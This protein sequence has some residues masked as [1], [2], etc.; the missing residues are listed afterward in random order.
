MK[1][2]VILGTAWCLALAGVAALAGPVAAQSKA[3]AKAAADSD[4][5]VTADEIRIAVVADV[6][7]PLKPGLFQGTVDGVN[8]A[9]KSVNANG[10]VAGRKLKVDFIDS[11]LNPATTRNAI[12]TACAED[13]ALVGTAAAFITNVDD[14][15]KC[16]DQSGA[17]TGLP[18]LASF[19]TGPQQCSPV[20]YPVNPSSLVCST[21]DQ[22]PQTYQGSTGV[23]TYLAEDQGQGPPRPLPGHQ[24]LGGR[25]NRA[26]DLL[27]ALRRGGWPE[28]R[29]APVR[30]Q[31]RRR[32]AR[33][34]RSC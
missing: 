5:G 34:H 10:G 8:A 16:V 3:A 6:D 33:T 22:H 29:P 12:I 23:P 15:T 19:V 26:Q 31:R 9:V 27:L 11:K 24:R 32:R 25:G 1:R 13:F 18:D 21:K 17:V 28:V 4:I 7:N 30:V 20:A 2:L 14:E